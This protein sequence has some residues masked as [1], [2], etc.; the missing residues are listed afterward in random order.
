MGK[1]NVYKKMDELVQSINDK[2]DEVRAGVVVKSINAKE[3]YSVLE[4]DVE[5]VTP[6]EE[7]NTY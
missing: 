5:F 4:G 3:K 6:A 2:R 7:P 1:E